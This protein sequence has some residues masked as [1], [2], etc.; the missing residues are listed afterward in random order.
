LFIYKV[1][2]TKNKD[3]LYYSI[4]VLLVICIAF[5]LKTN[6]WNKEVIG[7]D[8][9]VF[10]SIGEKMHEDEIPYKDVFDHKG[11][12]LY[13][14]NYIGT[15]SSNYLL[16]QLIETAFLMF[17]AVLLFK[18]SNRILN[19][20]LMSLFATV[21]STL[22]FPFVLQG[23]NFAEEYALPFVLLSLLIFLK[24][25]QTGKDY[26]ING[27]LLGIVVLLKFNMI[28][29]WCVGYLFILINRI[30]KKEYKNIVKMV[31]CSLLGFIVSIVPS[32]I[33][34]LVNGAFEDF[35]NQYII[36]NL[37][38]STSSDISVIN[39][40][41]NNRILFYIPG[42]ILAM[43]LYQ[44]FKFKNNKEYRKNLMFSLLFFVITIA[45][46]IMPR[47]AYLHYWL[48]LIPCYIIP[49]SYFT[50]N[51]KNVRDE[52]IL[53]ITTLLIIC[54]FVFARNMQFADVVYPNSLYKIS[55]R[56][57]DITYKDED[58]L[59][60]GNHLI[61]NLLTERTTNCKYIYQSPI[62]D[63]DKNIKHEV[64]VYIRNNLPD[65]IVFAHYDEYF[66]KLIYELIE[67]QIY[68]VDSVCD[69][70]II[71]KE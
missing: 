35:I 17:D 64:E 51:I 15:F 33:Y 59:V 68:Y 46:V 58:V 21:L 30:Y 70:V 3:I 25:V 24:N 61:I 65:I 45:T 53:A 67:K 55:E 28:S 40:I 43:N 32:I 47:N 57:E 13:F 22:T 23:G 6:A 37:K 56:I 2:K 27:I 63:V 69:A 50:K 44:I 8:S 20:K 9:S 52:V 36:F 1:E 38:Y 41:Y 5:S 60:L 7:V 18:I 49:I 19:N 12:I 34:L 29:V 62:S 71:K 26:M 42:F 16:L 10:V 66:E 4:L 39:F 48:G 14:I 11:P 31:G 54:I